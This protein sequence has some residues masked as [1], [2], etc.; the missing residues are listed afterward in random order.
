MIFYCLPITQLQC[1]HKIIK[2]CTFCSFSK[3]RTDIKNVVYR[4]KY[5]M[6]LNQIVQNENHHNTASSLVQTGAITVTSTTCKWHCFLQRVLH[7]LVRFILNGLQIISQKHESVSE[8]CMLWH[9]RKSFFRWIA[10]IW[11]RC[12]EASAPHGWRTRLVLY[13][14]RGM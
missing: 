1:F 6:K 5:R 10:H 2:N 3:I 8:H 7:P 13:V 11:Y 14:L 9:F 4:A 12:Q